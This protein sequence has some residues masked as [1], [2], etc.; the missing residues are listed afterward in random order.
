MIEGK[1]IF[2]LKTTGWQFPTQKDR[3]RFPGLQP[4]PL[5]ERVGKRGGRSSRQAEGEHP[6]IDSILK[7]IGLTIVCN[8][9]HFVG[10]QK[11]R[12]AIAGFGQIPAI[13]LADEPTGNL[14]SK[15]ETEVVS[16]LKNCVKEYNQTLVMITHDE[17]IAQTADVII[18]IEDGRVVR[19]S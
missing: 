19:R 7:R 9:E 12:V 16:L 3:I 5:S 4:D 11:Q 6:E 14:D 2:S 8:A 15:T 10:G 17:N 13:I 1:D 18:M